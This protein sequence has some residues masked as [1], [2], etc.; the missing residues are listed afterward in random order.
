MVRFGRQLKRLEIN[1]RYYGLASIANYCTELRELTVYQWEYR[2]IDVSICDGSADT[3]ECLNI[4]C[5][6]EDTR[7]LRKNQENFHHGK[8]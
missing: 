7:N 6:G 5:C 8:S 2:Q 4:D 3:L 1:T